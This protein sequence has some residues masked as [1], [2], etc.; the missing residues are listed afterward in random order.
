MWFHRLCILAA[1][2]FCLML[3]V[4]PSA[5]GQTFFVPEMQFWHNDGGDGGTNAIQYDMFIS[6]PIGKTG[7]SFKSWALHDSTDWGEI[8]AG[9]GKQ[10]APWLELSLQVGFQ[11][12][13]AA[14]GR[15]PWQLAS[16]VYL[17]DKRGIH[18]ALLIVEKGDSSHWY[19]FTW[20]AKAR[21]TKYISAGLLI[22]HTIGVGPLFQLNLGKAH[23]WSAPVAF[24]AGGVKNVT[25]L[26]YEF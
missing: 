2:F 20:L 16:T 18:Q 14:S 4:V 5:S 21:A 7:W 19:K 10:V 23:I 9:L 22:Q 15:K 24:G 12:V 25:G 17:T 26:K 13:D 6:T 8:Y 11:H 1:A 3:A